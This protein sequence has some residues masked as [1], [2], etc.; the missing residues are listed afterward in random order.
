MNGIQPLIGTV[1]ERL[2]RS[3][4]D[5]LEDR[6][7]VEKGEVLGIAH[8]ED[9]PHVLSHFAKAK[10]AFTQF[11]FNT[12]VLVNLVGCGHASD[13]VPVMKKRLF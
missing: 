9:F 10:F 4:P 3:P 5:F 11:F 8:P 1:I 2:P 7:E 12:G 6:T 13:S